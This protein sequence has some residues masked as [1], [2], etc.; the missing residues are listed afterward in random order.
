MS[1]NVF[2]V[3]I[4]VELRACDLLEIFRDLMA[5]NDWTYV[6]NILRYKTVDGGTVWQ[7][8]KTSLGSNYWWELPSLSISRVEAEPKRHPHRGGW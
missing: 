3:M 2:E 7:E 4:C 6:A 8:Y 1:E 5:D